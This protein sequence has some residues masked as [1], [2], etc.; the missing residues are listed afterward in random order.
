MIKQVLSGILLL[1]LLASCYTPSLTLRNDVPIESLG[2]CI[3]YADSIDPKFI[4][5]VDNQFDHFIRRYNSTH[6]NVNIGRCTDPVVQS[7]QVNIESHTLVTPAGQVTGVIGSVA[8]LVGLPILMNAVESPVLLFIAFN[9]RNKTDLTYSA[10]S[11]IA[12]DTSEKRAITAMSS[13]YF[14]KLDRQNARQSKSFLKELETIL[15]NLK[16]SPVKSNIES[17]QTP[18]PLRTQKRFF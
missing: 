17:E 16:F 1:L 10:S 7:I 6:T 9:P 2:I 4:N 3:N 11:D 18:K 8:G 12:A 15:A 13:A 5:Y 14:G